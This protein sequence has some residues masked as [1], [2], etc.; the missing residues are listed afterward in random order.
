MPISDM[1]HFD[2]DRDVALGNDTC[3]L[4]GSAMKHGRIGARRSS[5]LFVCVGC[6]EAGGK[7]LGHDGVTTLH[8]GIKAEPNPEK[9]P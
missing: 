7:R 6:S 2:A 1:I 8:V 9:A 3:D 4:C 5:L